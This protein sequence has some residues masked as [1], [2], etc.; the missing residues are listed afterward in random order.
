MD[1]VFVILHYT[2]IDM[3]I[4]CVASIRRYVDTGNYKIIIVDNCSPDDS[5]RELNVILGKD[6]DII[7]LHSDVNVGFARGN[8]I[9][10]SYANE[11]FHPEFLVLMN[12]D[13]LLIEKWIYKKLKKK[14]EETDYAVL[15]PMIITGE[16]SIC[17]SP[18]RKEILSV[19]AARRAVRRYYRL[20]RLNFFGL[21]KHYRW[22]MSKTHKH[23]PQFSVEERLVS[24]ENVGIH[25]C[26]MVF[27]E[28]YSLKFEGLDP[29]TFLYMEEDILFLHLMKNNMKS[30]YY[31][32]I[33]V[34]HKEDASTDSVLKSSHKKNGF[35]YKNCIN[36]LKS[37]LKIL[38]TYEEKENCNG[39]NGQ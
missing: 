22:L 3:T 37:Y 21:D 1:I 32:E 10:F 16:G 19:K 33:T 38:T 23:I 18:L 29:S 8:N 34:Y 27:S 26:F 31:P 39:Y 15:G 9:G 13:V 2:A 20:Y 36:S 14:Y 11:H 35:V 12:N 5:Y 28:N 6:D 7:L 17:S 4:S 30:I 24:H 25:G